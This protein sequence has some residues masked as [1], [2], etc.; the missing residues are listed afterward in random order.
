MKTIITIIILC[1]IN[2]LFPQ[3]TISGK[4]IDTDSIPVDAAA[5]SLFT[6]KN[7]TFIKAVLSKEDGTFSIKNIQ[8]NTYKIFITNMGYKD[9]TINDILITNS[10]KKLNTI[11]LLPDTQAIEA[12]TVTAKKP[13]VEV[14]PD[15]T[16]FNVKSAISVAGDSGFELLRK[17]PGVLIDNADNIVVEGKTG[18]LIYIDDKPSV[19]R[20]QDLVNYLKTIQANTIE[21]LEIITQPSSK[22]D[23]EGNAGIINI[24]FKRDKSLG[25]NG[26][27]ATGITIGDYARYNNTLTL[28]NRNKKTSLYGS[29]SNR[30]G[31]RTG[32]INLNRTQNNTNFNSR[33]T[34]NYNFNT[35]NIRLGFDYFANSK[36]TLGIILT[37]NFNDNKNTSN[38][39]T[40]IT[41]LSNNAPEEVLVA[42]NTTNA[43]TSN[44]YGNANYKLKL[45]NETALNID[46][47]YGQYSQE[48]T[49]LQPNTYL[50]GNETEV[51]SETIN[52]MN[53]PINIEILTTK[54]DY[55]Q[56]ILKGKLALGLKYSKIITDNQFDFFDRIAGEDIINQDRT[57]TFQY[58]ESIAAAYFN[59]NKKVKKINIQIGFRMEQTQSE[60]VLESLQETQNNRVKRNYTNWFPSGGI[61]YQMN[62]K[63]T[64]SLIYSKRIQRP[65]Y[66]SLNPFEY[67][68]DELSFSKGNPFLQ[69]QY[70]DNIKLTH[71]HNYTLNTTLSYSF[72]KDFSAQVTEAVGDDKNFLSS[73]NVANQK[74]INLGVSYPTS[75]NKWWSI[76]ISV[77]AYRSI[78]E[79]TT[80]DFLST[81]QNTLSIY[82]Q[83]TFKITKTFNAEISGWYSSP[84]VWGGTYQTKSLG[85]LNIAIQK[86]F[87][88]N[89]L[90]ARIAINDLLFTSP[91]RGTTQFGDL[92]I[93]GDGGSDSRQIQCNITYNFGSNDVK[94][95]RKRKTSIEDEKSRI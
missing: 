52:F 25:T 62:Q 59:Y 24:K 63:N 94:K 46:L 2:L 61:T 6:T 14:R 68:I 38:S 19:L 74:I 66:R 28:N 13:L 20:G 71:T 64:W 33:S 72:I 35:N 92:R 23:A 65:N 75:F 56:N 1:T 44:L 12:V 86:K 83:N 95:A 8:N 77:N 55:E 10:N 29:L 27:L 53:T 36:S 43:K 18:V 51:I 80:N 34:S 73:R 58:D 70:T 26:S 67:Q 87:L 37:G 57:N 89:K 85:A 30:L 7:N 15:K 42:Q 84:S 93:V 69:P 16:I 17:A 4:I 47:D 60:G 31:E 32:F 81:R 40:P 82:A 76:Y 90:N 78:Y 21:A 79:A 22:Y 88:Q 54:I 50:N 91:W 41:P 39:R 9:Y 48:R 5:V 45:E 3:Q 11:T 49:S